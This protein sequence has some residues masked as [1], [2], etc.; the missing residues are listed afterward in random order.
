M[1]QGG[2]LWKVKPTLDEGIHIV[3]IRDMQP[4]AL[5]AGCWCQPRVEA[6]QNGTHLVVHHAMDGRELIERHGIQ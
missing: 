1:A 2:A 5:V 6:Q 3:P 4:H